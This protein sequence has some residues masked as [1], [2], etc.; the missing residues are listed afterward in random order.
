M[1]VAVWKIGEWLPSKYDEAMNCRIMFK[2][3]DDNKT[4]YLNLS[5]EPR[6]KDKWWP[7]IKLGNLLDVPLLEGRNIIQKYGQPTLVK[8]IT[9]KREIR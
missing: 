5:D 2:G 6:V 8:E 3:L 9:N 7:L 1:I 4:Y